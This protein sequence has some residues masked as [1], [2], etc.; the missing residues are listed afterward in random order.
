MDVACCSSEQVGD[1]L[2]RKVIYKMEGCKFFP[3]IQ[4]ETLRPIPANH[5][6]CMIYVQEDGTGSVKFVKNIVMEKPEEWRIDDILLRNIKYSAGIRIVERFDIRHTS[7]LHF[8]KRCFN[9]YDWRTLAEGE[10]HVF[11][12]LSVCI[13]YPKIYK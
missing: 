9:K 13:V 3:E 11:G 6:L 10:T 12:K 4:S 2:F 7:L 5:F 8:S 1:L